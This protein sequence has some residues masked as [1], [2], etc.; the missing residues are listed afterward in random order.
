MRNPERFSSSER[1]IS[2]ISYTSHPIKINRK[3]LKMTMKDRFTNKSKEKDL[4]SP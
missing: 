1:K 4:I 3:R 2:L